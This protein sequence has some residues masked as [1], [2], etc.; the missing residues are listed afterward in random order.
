[1]DQGCE[2][3]VITSRLNK[4]LR[5]MSHDRKIKLIK[6]RIKDATVLDKF[7]D[8]FLILAATDDRRLNRKLVGKGRT[9]GAFVYAADDPLMS[10]FSY[11]SLV[12]IEGLVQVAISTSGKSPIMARKI[13]MK[14]ERMLNKVISES[15]ISNIILQ[16]FARKMAKEKIS[17]VKERKEFLYSL[18]KDKN[19]QYL[20]RS[21]K[22]DEAK[23]TTS[24]ML[25]NW[26]EA[27]KK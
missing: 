12:N 5:S 26:G 16:E 23:M 8:I 3:T 1:L 9:M 13:R 19:I 24:Y 4:E 22:L 7:N 18:I 14:A 21:N 11:T 20:L 2:I 25:K 17:T 10:D 15:D 27:S 6:R